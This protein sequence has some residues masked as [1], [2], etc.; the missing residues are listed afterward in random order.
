MSS[1]EYLTSNELI[2]YPFREDAEGLARHSE[3]V[4][5]GATATVPTDF[6]TDAV[7]IIPPERAA[8]FVYLDNITRAGTVYT[9]QVQN[10]AVITVLNFTIDTS[11]LTGDR[12]VIT[13]TD[14]NGTIVRFLVDQS[15]LDHLATITDFT[16]DTYGTRLPFE[17]AVVEIRPDRLFSIRVPDG[18]GGEVDL[19]DDISLIEGF[20]VGLD[21]DAGVAPIEPGADNTDI[22][23][24]VGPGLGDGLFDNCDNPPV[25][26]FLAKL[27]DASP[28][29][30]GNISLETGEC[31]STIEDPANNRITLGNECVPCCDCQD[32][33]N[34][35]KSL[36]NMFTTLS[37]TKTTLDTTITDLNDD[38]TD[39]NDNIFP[40]IRTVAVSGHG[41]RGVGALGS[42]NRAGVTVNINNRSGDD[43]VSGTLTVTIAGFTPKFLRYMYQETTSLDSALASPIVYSLPATLEAGFQAKAYIV[44]EKSPIASG[45]VTASFDWPANTGSPIEA[46]ITWD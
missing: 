1:T 7:I 24:D 20:N 26:D 18:G 14:P 11:T 41:S 31:H 22:T 25:I 4:A 28:D 35:T 30:N 36:E 21:L 2:A 37:G 23:I 27:G 33:A 32:Y 40:A 17:A 16:T 34:I 39:Y 46:V 38:I 8:D 13:N 19:I 44:L 9:F 6:L 10:S 3:V 12:E 43:V 45:T 29:E 5:H 15:F 42:Q